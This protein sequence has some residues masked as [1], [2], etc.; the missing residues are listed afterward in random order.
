MGHG[1]AGLMHAAVLP[2]QVCLLWQA[3]FWETWAEVYS[4]RRIA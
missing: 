1:N 2:L 4:C 3:V